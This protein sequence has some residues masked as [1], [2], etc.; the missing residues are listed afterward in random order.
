MVP[1]NSSFL[2][3]GVKIVYRKEAN[4]YYLMLNNEGFCWVL[5]LLFISMADI[6]QE[7]IIFFLI[8]GCLSLFSRLCFF[9]DSFCGKTNKSEECPIEDIMIFFFFGIL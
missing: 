9:N 8:R 3:C 2:Q 5:D 6:Y 1:M 4:T 7:I